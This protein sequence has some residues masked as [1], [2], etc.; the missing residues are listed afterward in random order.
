[1]DTPFLLG[2]EYTARHGDTPFSYVYK[3]LPV[4]WDTFSG[5]L[6]S[7]PDGIEYTSRN[8]YTPI[9]SDKVT[10]ARHGG[11]TFFQVYWPMPRMLILLG[12][13]YTVRNGNTPF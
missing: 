6:T 11:H 1:M 9:I 5:R 13:K 7:A 8:G 2:I 3:P 10:T 12:I 4:T